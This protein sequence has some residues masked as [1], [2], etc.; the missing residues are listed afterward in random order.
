MSAGAVGCADRKDEARPVEK[1]VEADNTGK[2]VRDREE[3]TKTPT[4]QRENDTDLRIT[5][6]I[7]Q[8]LVDDG[9]LSFDA[10]NVK[11][12]TAG[13]V[14]TLRGPVASDLEKASIEAKAKS[15]AGVTRVDNLLEIKS[16]N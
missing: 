13:S 5:A 9:A 6:D 7:R 1:P 10:K 8:A 12:I 15:V 4:D 11:I 3:P 2:N 14:V 16:T